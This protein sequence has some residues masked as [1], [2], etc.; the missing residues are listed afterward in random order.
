MVEPAVWQACPAP[1]HCPTKQQPPA[2]HDDP[3]QHGSPGP[4]HGLQTLF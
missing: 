4:P 1:T 2:L 3:S